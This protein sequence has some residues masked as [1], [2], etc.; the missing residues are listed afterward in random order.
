MAGVGQMASPFQGAWVLFNVLQ[1][2]HQHAI[3]LKN[4]RA[5][6]DIMQTMAMELLWARD[7]LLGISKHTPSNEIFAKAI[8]QWGQVPTLPAQVP[9]DHTKRDQEVNQAHATQTKGCSAA[10]PMSEA[11]VGRKSTSDPASHAPTQKI[12]SDKHP[13]HQAGTAAFCATEAGVEVQ[14]NDKHDQIEPEP[15]ASEAGW[16]SKPKTKP[17]QTNND[18]A[19][20]MQPSHIEA[21]AIFP[22]ESESRYHANHASIRAKCPTSGQMSKSADT[23]RPVDQINASFD[24]ASFAPE[25]GQVGRALCNGVVPLGSDV[26]S[27]AGLAVG[28]PSDM[29]SLYVQP[30]G[31]DSRSDQA[32]SAAVCEPSSSSPKCLTNMYEPHTAHELGHATQG[33]PGVFALPNAH[34]PP[35]AHGHRSLPTL[36]H[37]MPLPRLGC[38]GPSHDQRTDSS[39]MQKAT[40]GSS[41]CTSNQVCQAGPTDAEVVGIVAH[42]SGH[43]DEWPRPHT[44][45]PSQPMPLPR[46][47]CGGVPSNEDIPATARIA[48]DIQRDDRTPGTTLTWK[49]NDAAIQVIHPCL[50]PANRHTKDSAAAMHMSR[51]TPE[52]PDS[53]DERWNVLPV[54]SLNGPLSC[55]SPPTLFHAKPLPRLGCGGP[56][57]YNGSGSHLEIFHSEPKGF[58]HAEPIDQGQQS[59]ARR[60]TQVN[61][62]DE[63]IQDDPIEDCQPDPWLLALQQRSNNAMHL[64]H[65]NKESPLHEELVPSLPRLGCGVGV[66]TEMFSRNENDERWRQTESHLRCL[67]TPSHVHPTSGGFCAFA[68]CTGTAEH[69]EVKASEP[70]HAMQTARAEAVVKE[71]PSADA[72]SHKRTLDKAVVAHAKHRKLE[73]QNHEDSTKAPSESSSTKHSLEAMQSSISPYETPSQEELDLAILNHLEQLEASEPGPTQLD[74]NDHCKVAAPEFQASQPDDE[75]DHEATALPEFYVNV[76]LPGQTIFQHATEPK[77]TAASLAIATSKLG[78][79]HQPIRVSTAM[80]TQVSQHQVLKQNNFLMLE[81]N[82]QVTQFS[83][84]KS[85]QLMHLPQVAGLSREVALWQ[86]KGWVAADEMKYYMHML[87]SYHPSST[88]GVVE[89]PNNPDRDAMVVST[90]IQAL[91]RAHL[92]LNSQVKAIAFLRDNHWIPCFVEA[93]GDEAHVHLPPEEQDWVVEAFAKVVEEHEVRFH[94]SKVP[95]AFP[96]DCGFQAVGW[97]LAKLMGDDTTQPFTVRQ[98]CQW[99]SLCHQNMVHTGKAF[100]TVQHLAMG[101]ALHA[102]EQLQQLVVTHGVNP[103]RGAE[104]SEQLI[105]ALGIKQV[106]QILLSPKPWMDLKAKA[107]LHQPPIRVV[108]A[109]ELHEAIQARLKDPKQVGKKQNKI[110]G[111]KATKTMQLKADQLAIPMAVFRQEDGQEIGQIQANQ[112]GPNAM[113]VV[114][115]NIQEALPYFQLS[116]PVSQQGIALLILDHDDARLPPSCQVTKV[117]AKCLATNE[118]MIVSIAVLQIGA[119][120]VV[121]NLPTNC[122]EVPEVSHQVIR[123]QIYKDQC[124]AKWEELIQKPVKHLLN[125]SPFTEVASS[126]ILDVWDRQYMTARMMKVP[127]QEAQLFMVNLRVESEAVE[128]ILKTNGEDGR[129]YELRRHDGRQP[130]ESQQVVWLPGKT[131]AEAQVIQRA[132]KI[133]TSLVRQGDRYG[134]RTDHT[135]AEELHK[136]HRP[137]LVYIPGA[138]LK[139]YKVGPMPFGTTKQSLVHVF[140]KWDWCARPVGPIGQTGDRSGIMW[141]V[142]AATDPTHWVFQMAHGDVLV[143]PEE[144]GDHTN[145][146]QAN[147][148]GLKQNHPQ[149][150]VQ[151]QGQ[152]ERG[153][154]VA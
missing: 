97:L 146:C 28:F 142:Q 106:Q 131:F 23:T 102:K 22:S 133:E 118:P 1:N 12:A 65:E 35:S 117:P 34:G 69:T 2:I 93:K 140:Q 3:P 17:F 68:T 136:L 132:S 98:A 32:G 130:D 45:L 105:K 41:T 26:V 36:F 40:D 124:K 21:A 78:L 79:I 55:M 92:D 46:P 4:F 127:V 39:E 42:A 148:S 70:C 14:S 66:H 87:E 56:S 108:T 47:G 43:S 94:T 91:T 33:Q 138:D 83:C 37:A 59:A 121:R 147:H 84:P 10:H 9:A 11:G 48:H 80:G 88:F 107:S 82:H 114:L 75:C 113:G 153:P 8:Q 149:P 151:K 86:Q 50:P 53:H 51:A 62:H 74:P 143:S 60:A 129:F 125:M 49:A 73:E 31:R 144:K 64:T 77:C 38:G 90:I 63:A 52:N 89:L 123:V 145:A 71:H 119:Q 81:E 29:S 101:G 104:C 18:R 6:M 154:M 13:F 122:L 54:G 76:V 20:Q 44:A 61:A 19:N 141:N 15:S 134:L 139:K 58:S 135:K 96:A 57:Q 137:D 25:A 120:Q 110:K 27:Q 7:K 67:S 24:A 150:A 116:A 72:Q 111:Q 115:V 126:A 109:E 99:R 103:S 152:C 85:S 100:E 5:S 128:T 30:S 95:H 112:I 16:I